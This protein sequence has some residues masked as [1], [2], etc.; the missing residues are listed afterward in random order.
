MDPP[1]LRHLLQMNGHLPL[2]FTSNLVYEP[3]I[4]TGVPQNL[5]GPDTEPTHCAYICHVRSSSRHGGFRLNL[6]GSLVV[7][8]RIQRPVKPVIYLHNTEVT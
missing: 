2:P 3:R 6:A 4:P 5:S 1:I 8:A 7:A